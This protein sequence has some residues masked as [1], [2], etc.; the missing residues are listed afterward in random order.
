MTGGIVPP[1]LPEIRQQ[2]NLAPQWVG[3]LVGTHAITV[4]LFTPVLGILADRVGKLEVLVASLIGYAIAGSAGGFMN[5][6]MP[7]LVSRA[8]L[9]AASGGVTAAA[10]GFLGSMYVGE[11]RSRILGFATSAMTTAAVIVPLVAGWVGSSNWRHAFYLYALGFPLAV[12]AVFVLRGNQQQQAS[13]GEKPQTKELWKIIR[14]PATLSLYLTLAMAAVM[15]YS[16][17]IYAP[18]FLKA[19]INATPQLNGIVLGARAAGAAVISAV[20]A[21]WLAKRLGER[22]AIALGFTIMAVT[23]ITLPLL[24]QLQWILLTAI[25][26]GAGFGIITP[27]VY[28]ALAVTAPAELRASV[29]AIGTGFNSLGQFLSPILLGSIWQSAGSPVFWVAG[30]I[31][32]LTGILSLLRRELR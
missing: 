8:C 14:Q 12:V 9:G 3:T 17:V 32:F 16:V 15:M 6:L 29:L 23:L 25:L 24:Q 19:T 13:S 27:N 4:A 11:A 5:S 7:L 28:N 2:L 26:F 22:Q 18:L 10:I 1:V 21:S 31:A 20:G 30:A